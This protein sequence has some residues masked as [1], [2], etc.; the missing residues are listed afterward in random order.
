MSKNLLG[1]PHEKLETPN[2]WTLA[3]PAWGDK[4]QRMKDVKNGKV[5]GLLIWN[6]D[7][8]EGE[9][10][11][12]PEFLDQHWLVRADILSDFHGLV[13]RQYH[14]VITFEQKGEADE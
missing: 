7:G 13:S 2:D 4:K 14:D 10:V 5:V 9:V 1:R 3:V 8:H 11:F 12:S 6:V